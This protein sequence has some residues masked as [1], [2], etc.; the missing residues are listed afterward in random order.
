MESLKATDTITHSTSL[1]IRFYMDWFRKCKRI[2]LVAVLILTGCNGAPELPTPDKIGEKERIGIISG[3]KAAR[4]VNRMHGQPVATSE[5]AIAEYGRGE[6]KD[7]LYI[8][9]YPDPKAAQKA[10]VQ[11]IEKMAAAPQSP[12]SHLVPI[13]KYREKVYMTLGLGAVHYIYPSGSTLLW[14]QTFQSF[15]TELPPRLLAVYPIETLPTR[16]I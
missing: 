13:G 16:T 2:R 5:N 10:F 11:M 6:K 15:G 4:V 14:F 8:T 3:K 12:F 7:I 9:R 1:G